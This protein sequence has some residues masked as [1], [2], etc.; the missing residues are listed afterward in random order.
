LREVRAFEP[1]VLD[2]AEVRRNLSN[3]VV[4]HKPLPRFRVV[5]PLAKPILL[6]D[7]GGTFEIANERWRSLYRAIGQKLGIRHY[8]V[9]CE[10]PS[11][12]FYTHRRPP[13]TDTWVRHAEGVLLDATDLVAMAKSAAPRC[14]VN[15]IGARQE[16]LNQWFAKHGDDFRA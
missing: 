5:V 8:D 7:L 16:K 1:W 11:R 4:T 12:L 9:S 15:K 3:C 2:G 14:H 6:A 10:D 13:G